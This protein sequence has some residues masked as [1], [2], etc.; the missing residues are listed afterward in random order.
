VS[1][2]DTF[3]SSVPL[4]IED[5]P[6]ADC[7]LIIHTPDRGD[8]G[9][10]P[11]WF[12][13]EDPPTAKSVLA[14]TSPQI[15][16]ISAN[17]WKNPRKIDEKMAVLVEIGGFSKAQTAI[18]RC[19]ERTVLDRKPSGP[20]TLRPRGSAVSSRHFARQFATERQ[21]SRLASAMVSRAMSLYTNANAYD[22]LNL[23]N[24]ANYRST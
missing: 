1:E 21:F 18:S 20:K 8:H 12:K 3:A 13:L 7:L 10:D 16:S 9:R 5:P 17:P 23:H 11:A 2:R 19:S 4:P 14:V 22:G 24:R 6:L 15:E